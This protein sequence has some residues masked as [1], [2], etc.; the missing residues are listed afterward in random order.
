MKEQEFNEFLEE[1]IKDIRETLSLKG[2]EYAFNDDR[3]HNFKVAGRIKG[4]SPEEALYG[5][6]IKHL[7]SVEDLVKGRLENRRSI[8]AEKL[9]DVRNYLILL[10]ALFEDIRHTTQSFDK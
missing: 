5:M 2:N 9:G 6:L 8:V 7:V 10:E 4:E 1:K 3:L